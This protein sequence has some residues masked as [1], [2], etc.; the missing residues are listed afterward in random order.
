ML[1]TRAE[2]NETMA[3]RV[4]SSRVP[5]MNWGNVA[6]TLIAPFYDSIV[7]GSG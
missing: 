2:R 5:V 1:R 4:K 7:P 3:A 6:S